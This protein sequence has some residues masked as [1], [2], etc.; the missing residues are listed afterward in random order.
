MNND[1]VC[2]KH[3]YSTEAKLPTKKLVKKFLLISLYQGRDIPSLTCPLGSQ[4]EKED[5][6]GFIQLFY[7]TNT[8][9]L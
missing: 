5:D 8:C 2:K 6:G 7:I 3:F 4:R 9:F 1:N